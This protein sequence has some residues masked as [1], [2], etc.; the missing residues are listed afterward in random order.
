M[1][2]SVAGYQTKTTLSR[3]NAL[4]GVSVVKKKGQ[5]YLNGEPWDGD[6]GSV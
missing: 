2:V 3:L 5:L 4:P 1:E 6:W